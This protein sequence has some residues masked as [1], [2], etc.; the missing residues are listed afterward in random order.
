M[1]HL[2]LHSGS[3]WASLVRFLLSSNYGNFRILGGVSGGLC[4][5]LNTA[6]GQ[7]PATTLILS[8]L[9]YHYNAYNKQLEAWMALNSKHE[10]SSWVYW[11]PES[12]LAGLVHMAKVSW[13]LVDLRW[14]VAGTTRDTWV[15]CT[16][17][18]SSS[19]L[20][21]SLSLSSGRGEKQTSPTVHT[22]LKLL[23]KSHFWASHWPK[24]VVQLGPESESC[25]VTWPKA[26]IQGG[27][28]SGHHNAIN[29]PHLSPIFFLLRN[30]RT[31]LIFKIKSSFR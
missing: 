6:P 15:W 1:D 26:W 25:T 13:L 5:P 18:S 16:H 12:F 17:F 11:A 19:I 7:Q 2:I 27:M 24:R 22:L 28:K 3:I 29:L 4:V 9:Y 10:F 14:F 31:K 8:A 23:F 30:V 21:W 20:A